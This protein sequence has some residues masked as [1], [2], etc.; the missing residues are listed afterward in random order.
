M[1]VLDAV[2]GVVLLGV[3]LLVTLYVR[4]ATLT[5]GRGSF[6][7]SYRVSTATDGRGWALGFGKY[8]SDD[9]QW[10]RVFSLDPRPSRTLSRLEL[11]VFDR[12]L[13]GGAESLALQ[14]NMVV[15]RCRGAADDVV[16]EIAMSEP[17]VTGF[18]AWLEAQAPGSSSG[19]STMR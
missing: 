17:A 13:P 8:V 3:L 5:R 19:P 15:L 12:R 11:E 7:M 16:R 4:R 2:V 10:Y 18:L 1:I 14:S 9:L 6:E